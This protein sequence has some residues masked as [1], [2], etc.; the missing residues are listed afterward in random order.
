LDLCH[1]NR[2]HVA[3]TFPAQ[4]LGDDV[5]HAAIALAALA[6]AMLCIIPV[7]YIIWVATT[8]WYDTQEKTDE[9]DYYE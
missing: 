8:M 7:V 6:I 3:A 2:L 9:D 5:S 1:R 4:Q